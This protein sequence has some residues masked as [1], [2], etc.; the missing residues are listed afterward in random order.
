MNSRRLDSW[1]MLL[2]PPTSTAKDLPTWTSVTLL[3]LSTQKLR[4]WVSGLLVHTPT[5]PRHCLHPLLKL[6]SMPLS[7]AS[8]KTS[9]PLS[10]ETRATTPATFVVKKGIRPMNVQTRL[11]SK[12][13][14]APTQPSPMDTLQDLHN[15]LDM[16]I[17]TATVDT[18]KKDEEDNRQTNKVGNTFL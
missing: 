15:V 11:A 1:S 4:P 12:P 13:S 18:A 2:E 5:T 17:H 9:P 6:K 14:I 3:K 8:K 10:H 16:K 7:S